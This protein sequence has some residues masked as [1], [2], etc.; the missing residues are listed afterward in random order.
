MDYLTW[1]VS[2]TAILLFNYVV[3]IYRQLSKAKDFK[4]EGKIINKKQPT[5]VPS[6][7]FDTAKANKPV[8]EP[9]TETPKK[10]PY[11][12]RYYNNKKP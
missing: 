9:T 1:G 5:S 12:K 4:E 2:L 11:K 8:V 7:Y 3:Y 10:K 6:L